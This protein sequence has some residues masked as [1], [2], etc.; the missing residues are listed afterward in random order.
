[1][2]DIKF[3]EELTLN[4]ISERDVPILLHIGQS[5][6]IKNFMCIPNLKKKLMLVNQIN[7]LNVEVVEVE[8][9]GGTC[10]IKG[11]LKGYYIIA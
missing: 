9:K 2:G 11:I 7:N 4:I 6:N 3:G 8:F 1:M 10:L 5:Y